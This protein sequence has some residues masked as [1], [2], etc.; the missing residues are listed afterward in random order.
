MTSMKQIKKAIVVGS[1][2]MASLLLCIFTSNA[3]QQTPAPAPTMAQATGQ[4]DQNQQPTAQQPQPV[5]GIGSTPPAASTMQT[6]TTTGPMP[7]PMAPLAATPTDSTMQSMPPVTIDSMTMP[8]ANTFQPT[9]TAPP[10]SEGQISAALAPGQST[11]TP[12]APLM[13]GNPS[14]PVSSA[15]MA[16]SQTTG[17]TMPTPAL[18][19]PQ[20]TGGVGLSMTNPTQFPITITLHIVPSNRV[21]QKDIPAGQTVD[22][23]SEPLSKNDTY[24]VSGSLFQTITTKTTITT[25]SGPAQQTQPAQFINT[26][27]NRISSTKN[28][29]VANP[30][31]Q[32]IHLTV[33]FTERPGAES[34]LEIRQQ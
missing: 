33:D 2:T 29:S 8:Q 4:P 19:T 7:T 28:W 17:Q 31:D 30:V 13:P 11:P 27:T 14:N 9:V 16:S 12:A 34:T 24:T 21:V 18:N 32:K 10:P 3:S 6:G 23:L 22:L 20:A 15:P 5:V 1:F 26:K 25:L